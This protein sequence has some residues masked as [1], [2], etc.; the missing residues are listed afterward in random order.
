MEVSSPLS[1]VVHCVW[2]NVYSD[3]LPVVGVRC[4]LE[5]VCVCVV[6]LSIDE[7]LFIIMKNE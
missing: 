1:V 5:V 3:L 7:E 6:C 2:L 4:C